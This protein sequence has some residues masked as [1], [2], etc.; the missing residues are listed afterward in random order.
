MPWETVCS[1]PSFL[2]CYFSSVAEALKT[3]GTVEPEYFDQVTIYFND[4]VGF[5]SISALSEPIEVVDLLND[6]YSLFDAVLGNH[7]VYKVRSNFFLCFL[8]IFF[9]FY[10]FF[11][12]QRYLLGGDNWW[13]LHGCF[14][15]PQTERKQA[16]SRN[17]QHVLGHPQLR[18]NIQN[19]A[20]ARCSPQDTDRATHR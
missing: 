11:S 14:R 12:M 17:S 9:N 6:L 7:D 8:S 20:H 18:G 19:E 13:C 1:L 16:C 15:A 4:I 2:C 5:T 10:I 3:G